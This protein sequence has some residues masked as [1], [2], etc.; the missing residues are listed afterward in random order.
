M[1]IVR[2]WHHRLM[3]ELPICLVILNFSETFQIKPI[4]RAHIYCHYNF[5]LNH[6]FIVY[7]QISLKLLK[8]YFC[9]I[10]LSSRVMYYQCWILLR[11][12]AYSQTQRTVR[13]PPPLIQPHKLY[14]S[15]YHVRSILYH[16]ILSYFYLK[17]N[18]F[19][20][21]HFCLYSDFHIQNDKEEHNCSYSIN[22]EH[23]LLH[24]KQRH[25]FK[26]FFISIQTNIPYEIE[27]IF[28]QMNNKNK[29]KTRSKWT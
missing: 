28:Y 18:N 13:V 19:Y 23:S 22:I 1:N 9:D 20:L 14:H 15:G 29:L 5:F 11:Y 16:W 6:R 25:I 26:I 7:R 24:Y 12:N 4:W 3:S 2:Q 8:V 17:N 27:I 21:K 10:L